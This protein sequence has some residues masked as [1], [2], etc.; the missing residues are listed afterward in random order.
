M[1]QSFDQASSPEHGPKRLD[2]LRAELRGH[3]LDGF[4]VPRADKHQGEYVAP[5]DERLAWLTG[6]TGS[7]GFCIALEA[8]AGVFIDGRYRVQVKAQVAPCFTPVHWPETSPAQWLKDALGEGVVGF[9]PWLHTPN[10]ID[11]IKRGL[12]G[13][14]IRLKPCENMIDRIWEDQPAPPMGPIEPYP[15]E[16]A[17][18]SYQDKCAMVAQKLRENNQSAVVITLPDSLCWLLNVRGSDVAHNPVAHGFVVVDSAAK[19]HLF[20]HSDKL[21]TL[22]AHFG[23]DVTLHDPSALEDHLS[24]LSGTVSVDAGSVPMAILHMLD[25]HGASYDLGHDPCAIPKARKNPTELAKARESHLR[26]AGVMCEFLAWVDAQPIGELTEID[27]AKQ[28]ESM[29][30][31]TG[32]L[33][34]L[35]FESIVGSG[36][37]AALPHYRVSTQSNRTLQ[38]GEVL[39]VDSGGQY[40]DGT[41]DITRTIAIGDQSDEVKRAFTRVLKGMIAISRLKFPKGVA[42]CDLDAFARAAL[43]AAGQDFAHGTG[44]G[45]GHYL[46]VHEGPQRLSRISKVP[47]EQGMIL[48][49]EPGFYKEGHFGIRIENLIIVQEAELSEDANLTALYDFE[50]L[51]YVPIDRRMII[52]D[53]L[54]SDERDW[55]NTYHATCRDKMNTRVSD[56]TRIWL[57]K[58]TQQI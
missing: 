9:D 2:Q 57:E 41:T 44:H 10:E 35:S 7:A 52:A 27:V 49:N 21:T 39:L 54:N 23:S 5:H 22:G 55:I 38:N 18:V 31:A 4:I 25:K 42:G 58:A 37:N 26:D 51:T 47:F 56:E 24:K 28:L 11:A 1:F 19:V 53:M 8:E 36:P 33:R 45:V 32:L 15:L 16:L 12:A 20:A 30:M 43:W 48:S 6:F 17:G 50:T 34:D 3:Q 46:S 13:S 29:R 14:K 40:L